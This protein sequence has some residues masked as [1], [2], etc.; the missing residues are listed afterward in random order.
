MAEGSVRRPPGRSACRRGSVIL[1]VLITMFFAAMAIAKFVERAS[2]EML[3]EGRASDRERLR[4]EAYSALEVTLAVLQEFSSVNNGLHSP[5]EGWSDP[6]EF[7][8]Y[9][10]SGNCKAEVQFEDESGKL[11]LPKADAV[12]LLT[13]FGS[14]GL[15][16]VDSERLVDALL[17]WMRKDYTPTSGFSGSAAD[18]GREELPYLPPGRSLRSFNELAAIRGVREFFYDEQGRPNELWHQFA[19]GVSLF[20]FDASNLNGANASTLAAVAGYNDAQ[21]H[22]MTDYLNGTGS[23]AR[24]GPGWFS[25]IQ[26]AVQTVGL[27]APLGTLGTEI[28]A[29]RI[30]VTVH[31]GAASFRLTAVVTSGSDAKGLPAA[32]TPAEEKTVHDQTST[33]AP[34]AQEPAA[35]SAT[36]SA[37]APALN[38][39]FKLLEIRE[40]DEIPQLSLETP[41][42][43]TA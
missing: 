12:T 13:L 7:A 40:N 28:R 23:Y 26:T 19:S 16:K 33:P 29:L 9:Q 38:Y 35:G 22:A 3:T 1:F 4:R 31:D 8:G 42:Q 43:P 21:Q 11:S 37:A 20:A 17:V 36:D 32:T 24:Q 41:Q 25:N 5:A 27:P 34:T 30:N 15:S 2:L 10:P 39:P 18:Y 14:Y 6:L